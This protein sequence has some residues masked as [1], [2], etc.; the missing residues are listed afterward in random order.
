MDM[1]KIRKRERV[2]KNCQIYIDKNFENKV[3]QFS[4]LLKTGNK[5][6]QTQR[7]SFLEY[8]S[9]RFKK[10]KL[11]IQD[12]VDKIVKRK[13]IAIQE[14]YLRKSI[15]TVENNVCDLQLEESVPFISSKI[16]ESS[17]RVL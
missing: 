14:P 7:E 1:D 5:D 10:Q 9:T 13:N 4:I 6:K 15:K 12:I 8:I 16:F 3:T 11:V 2:C 17:T